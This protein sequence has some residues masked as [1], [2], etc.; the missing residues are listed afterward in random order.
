M[1]VCAWSLQRLERVL[2][3]LEAE[4]H[5]VVNCPVGAGD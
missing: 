3:P 2:D 4:L 5:M 1:Y